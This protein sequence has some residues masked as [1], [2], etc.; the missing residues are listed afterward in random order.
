[1]LI[2]AFWLG[3][4]GWLVYRDLWPRWLP[5]EPP[6]FAIDLADEASEQRV[7]W[8]V[9]KDQEDR[10]FAETSVRYHEA[11]DTFEVGGV[12]KLWMRA[13]KGHGDPD[14]VLEGR[15]RV[16]REGNLR[17]LS[18]TVRVVFPLAVVV[19]RLQGK[20][21]GQDFVSQFSFSG[22]SWDL[23]RDLKPVPVSNRGSVLNPLQPLNK[24]R[25]LRPGQHWRM[26]LVE[27]LADTLKAVAA[28]YLPG[29]FAQPSEV[30]M[31]DVEVLPDVRPLP[32]LK[33]RPDTRYFPSPPRRFGTPCLVV[34]FTGDDRSGRIWVREKDDVVLRQEVT[35]HNESWVLDR[36]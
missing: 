21:T 2:V 19:A 15:Y 29:V 16:T 11:D 27:P 5:G 22:F 35:L 31:V 8:T 25:G 36:D 32:E 4:M 17:Q 6:P 23:H 13:A 7:L 30:P 34:S 26:P 9:Y 28:P 20:V 12:V 18:G 14:Q 33:I 10:G 3:T 24:L 1:M